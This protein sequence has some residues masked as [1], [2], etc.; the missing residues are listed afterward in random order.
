MEYKNNFF[1]AM[2]PEER[3]KNGKSLVCSEG[4]PGQDLKCETLFF[5]SPEDIFFRKERLFYLGT[6]SLSWK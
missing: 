4:E 3:K 1:I 5:S 6:T 2:A